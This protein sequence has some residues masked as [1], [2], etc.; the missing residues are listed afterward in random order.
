MVPER[1]SSVTWPK[2]GQSKWVIASYGPVR[3][4]PRYMAKVFVNIF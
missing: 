4:E 1:R 3:E 2:V